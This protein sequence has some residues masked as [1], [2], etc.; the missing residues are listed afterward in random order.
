MSSCA[1]HLA[2]LLLLLS[3][4]DTARAL[5]RVPL[6]TL[7]VSPMGFGTLNLPLDKTEAAR[8]W[9]D[10]AKLGNADCQYCLGTCFSEGSGVPQ[11][12]KEAARYL[13]QAAQQG[14]ADAACHLGWMYKVGKGGLKADRAMAVRYLKARA[15]APR[16]AL[17]PSPL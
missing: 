15:V 8:W 9:R 5:T 10:G 16:H 7:S 2:R 13:T 14:H 3:A 12:D 17:S 6:G 11:S 1:R 4:V